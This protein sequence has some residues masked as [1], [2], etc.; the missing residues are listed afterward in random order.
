MSGPVEVLNPDTSPTGELQKEE[1]VEPG[2]EQLEVHDRHALQGACCASGM[3]LALDPDT[4]PP[5]EQFKQ[6]EELPRL[7]DEST[8]LLGQGGAS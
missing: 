3:G 6:R 4:S 8:G 5:G 1:P 2:S 7:R